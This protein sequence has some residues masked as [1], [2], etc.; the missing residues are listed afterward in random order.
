MSGQLVWRV[1]GRR[2]GS[3]AA[4]PGP[5]HVAPL[6][7]FYHGAH[8]QG[9]PSAGGGSPELSGKVQAPQMPPQPQ[10]TDMTSPTAP[11]LPSEDSCPLWDSVSGYEEEM[12]ACSRLAPA[13]VS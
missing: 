5:P 6:S 8:P 13:P 11:A 9:E 1:A 4:R 10:N 12:E 2:T 7:Q 3:A